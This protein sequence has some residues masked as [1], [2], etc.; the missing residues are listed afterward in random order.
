MKT[1]TVIAHLE[2]R[3]TITATVAYPGEVRLAF[4]CDVSV[5]I[6]ERV[7]P[8][9]YADICKRFDLE[10]DTPT[11]RVTGT[12]QENTPLQKETAPSGEAGDGSDETVVTHT[13]EGVT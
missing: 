9:A 7:N 12:I 1:H 11:L 4:G 2:E 3:D 8:E 10:D 6:Y 13:K 5:W